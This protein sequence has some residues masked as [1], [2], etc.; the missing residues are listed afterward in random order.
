MFVEVFKALENFSKNKNVALFSNFIRIAKRLLQM[1]KIIKEKHKFLVILF[2]VNKK[3][4]MLVSITH[5]I[6]IKPL[7]LMRTKRIC[8]KVLC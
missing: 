2:N 1:A 4:F 6:P 8:N 5:I 7:K 3:A